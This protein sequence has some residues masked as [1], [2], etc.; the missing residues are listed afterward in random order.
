MGRVT[1]GIIREQF[2]MTPRAVRYYEESGLIHPVRDRQ[3]RRRYSLED[4]A[5]LRIIGLLRTGGLGM[6]DIRFVL[7]GGPEQT[8]RRGQALLRMKANE[9]EVQLAAVNAATAA[10]ATP[11]AI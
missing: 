7:E 6:D 11:A 2:G 3:N 9:L 4:R 10:L 8:A 1:L 5:R